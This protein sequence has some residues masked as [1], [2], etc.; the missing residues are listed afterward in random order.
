L[1]GLGWAF[2][3]EKIRNTIRKLRVRKNF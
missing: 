1:G 2:K 3:Y